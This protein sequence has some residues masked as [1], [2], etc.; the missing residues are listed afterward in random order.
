[1]WGGQLA[2]ILTAAVNDDRVDLRL[3]L[4]NSHWHGAERLV[5]LANHSVAGDDSD[6]GRVTFSCID[7]S[8][9]AEPLQWTARAGPEAAACPPFAAA[10]YVGEFARRGGTFQSR[11]NL[12]RCPVRSDAGLALCP[13]PASLDLGD[14]ALAAHVTTCIE[15]SPLDPPPRGAATVAPPPC[16]DEGI[17]ASP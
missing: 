13:A 7:S 9:R 10:V 14:E 12:V 1:M 15:A 4:R 2:G 17:G 11:A 5:G 8:L 3:N 16:L 6:D